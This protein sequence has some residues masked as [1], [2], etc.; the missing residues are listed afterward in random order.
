MLK[1]PSGGHE[2]PVPLSR[3]SNRAQRSVEASI[4][5]ARR[6]PETVEA[7]EAPYRVGGHQPLRRYP[8]DVDGERRRAG[9]VSKRRIRRAMGTRSG[10]VVADHADLYGHRDGIILGPSHG[11]TRP[12]YP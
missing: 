5:T 10:I 4:G 9:R 11:Q 6:D 1:A 3:P 12:S 8:P 2:G 7:L